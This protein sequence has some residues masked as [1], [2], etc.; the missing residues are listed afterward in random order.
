[1]AYFRDNR[2]FQAHQPSRTDEDS[3]PSYYRL[4][5]D[6]YLV[7]TSRAE[8][9]PQLW[10]HYRRCRYDFIMSF[11][12]YLNENGVDAKVTPLPREMA[13]LAH[14]EIAEN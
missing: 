4:D 12:R 5:R 8:E 7:V 11:V 3:I 2:A 13:F 9:I 1:M 10:K 14:T 6:T